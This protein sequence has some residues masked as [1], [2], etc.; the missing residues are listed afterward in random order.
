MYCVSGRRGI[1]ITAK[2][3]VHN[4]HTPCPSATQPYREL[5]VP[6]SLLPLSHHNT[7]SFS[8]VLFDFLCVLVYFASEVLLLLP[9]STHTHTHPHRA[10]CY[11]IFIQSNGILMCARVRQMMMLIVYLCACVCVMFFLFALLHYR[12]HHLLVAFFLEICSFCH[13][14]T[15]NFATVSERKKNIIFNSHKIKNNNDDQTAAAAAAVTVAAV[16][17]LPNK[18]I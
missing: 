7:S 3:Y 14:A 1:Y 15:G 17:S 6:S 18:M 5:L 2:W 4:A 10:E 12:H 9:P 16:S 13:S 8:A 11:Q